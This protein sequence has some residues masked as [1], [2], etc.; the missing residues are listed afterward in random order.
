AVTTGMG[1]ASLGTD[2]RASIRVPAALCGLVGLKPTYGR[3]PTAGVVTLSW[4]MDH[5][6]PMATT[7]ADAATM[8]DALG[9][10]PAPGGWMAHAAEVDTRALRLGLSAVAFAEA[11]AEVAKVVRVAAEEL[12]RAGCVIGEADHPDAVDFDV[13]NAAG[14]LVSRCEATTQHRS[15]ALDRSL[16]WEEVADQLERAESVAAVDYLQ[17]QRLRQDLSERLLAEFRSHDVLVMPTV[18]V[19]APP[20]EDFAAYLMRLARTAI[21]FSFVG[22]PAMTVPCGTVDGL[23]VGMQLVAPPGREDLLFAVGLLVER[24]W[25]G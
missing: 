9:P 2:T 18:P 5:V 14:L 12:Q 11:D 7:V 6:A 1:L 16:Y 8:L 20:I 22:F 3:V 23:P 10:A 15:F 13:A 19:V 21:P 17:A 25:R 4:T 24:A